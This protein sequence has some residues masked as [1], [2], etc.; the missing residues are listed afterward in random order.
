MIT[1][2]ENIIFRHFKHRDSEYFITQE[3]EGKI[4]SLVQDEQIFYG[5]AA[6]KKH[7]EILREK[8]RD[9]LK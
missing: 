8:L 5:I 4:I 3:I 1:K 6:S 7:C 2:F 9:L